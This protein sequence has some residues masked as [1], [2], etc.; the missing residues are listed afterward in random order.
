MQVGSFCYNLGSAWGTF[1]AAIIAAAGAITAAIIAARV[2]RANRKDERDK[3]ER[4][5]ENFLE[6]QKQQRESSEK[7]A[8]RQVADGYFF[9]LRTAAISEMVLLGDTFNTSE[10]RRV[11]REYTSL[12]TDALLMMKKGLSAEEYSIPVHAK[13]AELVKHLD[14]FSQG[15][16]DLEG[17][18]LQFLTAYESSLVATFSA[19]ENY[20]VALIISTG[21]DVKTEELIS[22]AEGL[23]F[24]EATQDTVGEMVYLTKRVARRGSLLTTRQFFQVTHEYEM[25]RKT[26]DEPYNLGF[27]DHIKMLVQFDKEYYKEFECF[28]YQDIVH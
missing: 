10:Y 8:Q 26:L 16:G 6:Q 23:G 13:Q 9:E 15:V 28:L 5:Q 4:Q 25:K 3:F 12:L 14:V 11:L 7:I 21:N 1:F 22:L 27:Y 2:S 19:L 24:L 17:K 20:I 18:Y